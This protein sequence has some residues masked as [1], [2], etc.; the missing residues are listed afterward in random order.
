MRKQ[1]KP[2]RVYYVMCREPYPQIG[3]KLV[4]RSG[5]PEEG[6]DYQIANWGIDFSYEL[7]GAVKDME[8]FG[9]FQENYHPSAII[10]TNSRD[11]I[12]AI[13]PITQHRNMLN[14]KGDSQ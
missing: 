12:K 6:L 1:Q 11:I 10:L 3:E 13:I 5:K 9:V 2:L 8:H 4:L 14:K 7:K